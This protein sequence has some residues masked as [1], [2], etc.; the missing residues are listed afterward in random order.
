MRVHKGLATPI[1]RPIYGRG[2]RVPRRPRT[3]SPSLI[4]I[5][6]CAGDAEGNETTQHY[7]TVAE[8]SSTDLSDEPAKTDTDDN[9]ATTTQDT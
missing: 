9:N 2:S 6:S 1:D 7:H 3:W 4:P 5:P 8:L